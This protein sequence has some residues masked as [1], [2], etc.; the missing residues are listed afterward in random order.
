MSEQGSRTPEPVKS[1]EISLVSNQSRS[2]V[3]GRGRAR[4]RGR[5][6][7]LQEAP[8]V[9]KQERS[10][11]QELNQRHTEDS[12][13]LKDGL[14]QYADFVLIEHEGN[15]EYV[16]MFKILFNHIIFVLAADTSFGAPADP[17]GRSGRGAR[18]ARGHSMTASTIPR[19]NSAAGSPPMP[20]YNAT[21]SSS[22]ASLIDQEDWNPSFA[23]ISN[24][25]M[26]ARITLPIGISNDIIM[27]YSPGKSQLQ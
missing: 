27:Q 6:A 21:Q 15:K 8:G 2:S 3:R 24:P 5:I 16:T 9:G 20:V 18:G 11:Q 7:A 13:K 22:S 17:H 19:R 1:G 10:P 23:P 14:G 4:G 25:G 12:S 26:A